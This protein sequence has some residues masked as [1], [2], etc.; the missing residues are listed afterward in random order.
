MLGA[1]KSTGS[2]KS[3]SVTGTISV[4]AVILRVSVFASLIFCDENCCRKAAFDPDWDARP[5]APFFACF[6][7]SEIQFYYEW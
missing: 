5:D 7:P 2:R 4:V 6:V 3:M 1:L